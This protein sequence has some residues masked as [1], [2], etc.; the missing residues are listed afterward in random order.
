MKINSDLLI[1][2]TS[3]CGEKMETYVRDK[4]NFGEKKV[5]DLVYQ[6]YA[7]EGKKINKI[8]WLFDGNR[9]DEKIMTL[10]K[11]WLYHH[12]SHITWVLFHKY[13]Y[14]E[15]QKINIDHGCQY[16]VE[17]S[18]DTYKKVSILKEIFENVDGITEL[19]ENGTVYLVNID[20]T[21]IKKLTKSFTLS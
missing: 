15:C 1:H 5:E 3:V 13:F 21:F 14:E 18:S 9:V 10:S 4:K 11:P 6:L 2:L 8:E 7:L 19:D 16:F 12:D 20:F 17:E